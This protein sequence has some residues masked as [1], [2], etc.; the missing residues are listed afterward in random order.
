MSEGKR[1]LWSLCVECGPN[2]GVDED[3]LCC[4]CGATCTGD[5][6]DKNYAKLE[7]ALGLKKT[8]K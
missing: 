5:W 3:A 7:K 4:G 8:K 6:L 2:V 1:R